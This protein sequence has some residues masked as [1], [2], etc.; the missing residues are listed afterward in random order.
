MAYDSSISSFTTKTDKVD[1]VA[2]SHINTVQAELVTIET[3]LGTNV[4][5]TQSD[6]KTRLSKALD[7]DGSI[8][9]GTSYP[10]PALPS[11]MF[12]KTDVELMY[13]RDSL[14]TSWTQLGQS[15]SNIVFCY[16]LQGDN[17]GYYASTSLTGAATSNYSF[18]AVTGVNSSSYKTI[19]S[20]KLI[21]LSGVTTVTVW[22][23]MWQNGGSGESAQCKVDI[24]G[25]NGS[26]T[27]TANQQ[28][29][30]WKS[31]TINISGLTNGATYDV[32]IQL[33]M[34]GAGSLSPRLASIIAFGS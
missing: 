19:I 14:N 17:V 6:L 24:G 30:E 15:L 23:Y 32:V 25:A 29:P 11:Q 21:K 26:V 2:A 3:I 1:I 5:G 34:S 4:K 9:S 12:Y 31:F 27:G 13:V 8:V 10:S 18:W 7:T 20:T 22:A 16:G 28:T 33:A